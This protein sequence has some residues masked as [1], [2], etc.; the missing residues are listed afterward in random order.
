MR[1]VQVMQFGGP[2]VLV[3]REEPDPVAVAGQVVV[4]VSCA[5]VLFLDTQLRS[6]WG[7]EYFAMEPPY[8]PGAGVAGVVSSVGE[9]ME[10]GWIGRRVIAGTGA[11]GE[12]AGGGYAERTAAPVGEV[13]GVPEG[14]DL[15]EALAALHDGRMALSQAE[16]A[17]IAPGQWVLVGAAGG[18]LGVWLVPLARAAGARVIAAARGERKLE[19][20]RE[21]GAD[22]VVDYSEVGW[23]ERVREAT[24]GAGI[25]VVFDGAGGQ[26]GRAAF[27]ITAPGG[28]FF[29]YGAA[30]GGFAEIDAHEAEQRQVTVVGIV[31]RT[32]PQEW[33][34]LTERALSEL[35]AGRIRPVIGQTFPL[36]R[37]ADAHA[38]I[39]ARDVIGKTL[40]LT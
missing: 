8:V 4:D 26:V 9:G 22:V 33:T 25:D 7:Q 11:S 28:R 2:E 6:G 27:E 12:Y 20:A 14:L 39:E 35:A 36:E 18:S 10:V 13:F 40:L 1:V 38:A 24:G 16:K 17:A 37:A 31:D 5:E 15:A 23:A 3:L 21:L 30:S 32:A 34:R 29:S 19:H